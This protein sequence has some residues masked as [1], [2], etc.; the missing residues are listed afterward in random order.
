METLIENRSVSSEL[1]KPTVEGRSL[2]GHWLVFNQLSEPLIG[3][4]GSKT[5]VFREK[6][7]SRALDNTDFTNT[8]CCLNHDEG[9]KF[10]GRVPN[11]LKIAKDERG[12]TF[13]CDLPELPIGNEVIEFTTR[14]DY[15]GNSF[16]FITMSG[17]DTWERQADGTYIREVNNIRAVLHLGPVLDPAYPQTDLNV[18]MRSL[19]QS[20]IMEIEKVEEPAK[21]CNLRLKRERQIALNKASINLK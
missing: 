5:V 13:S 9:N 15:T 17:D 2:S 3:K 19:E 10:L 14:G 20:G 6:I 8:K 21:I 18:A 7:N 12:M 1:T 11:T 16:R 4:I